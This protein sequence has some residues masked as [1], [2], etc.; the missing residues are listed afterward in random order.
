MHLTVA[1]EAVVRGQLIGC[2]ANNLGMIFMTA[3]IVGE[4]I[5]I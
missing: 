5:S 2:S 1:A 3:W 4:I